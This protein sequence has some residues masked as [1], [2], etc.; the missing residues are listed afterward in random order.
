M[1]GTKADIVRKD[2]RARQVGM[3]VNSI[4]AEQDGDTSPRFFGRGAIVADQ[5][6]PGRGVGALI[7]E[8]AGVAACQDRSQ[9]ITGKLGRSD[10]ADVGLDR[11]S[12]LLLHRHAR[13]QAV[14]GRFG[15]AIGNGGRAVGR[16]PD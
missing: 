12:D 3:T 15:L 9:G 14:D 8:W 16:G 11:L 2:G 4:D 10:R 1:R 6:D 7:A 5:L 13:D